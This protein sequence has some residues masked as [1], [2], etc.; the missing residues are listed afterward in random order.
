[1]L[2]TLLRRWITQLEGGPA[3]SLTIREIFRRFYGVNVGL[4]SAG[5]CAMRPQL[6]H[7]GTNIGRYASIF[8][9]VRTFT[10]NHTTSTKST[11]GFFDNPA[12]GKVTTDLI[13]WGKLVIG[14]GV[15]IGHNAIVLPPTETIG[16][17]AV[18]TAGSVVCANVPPYAIV[19]GFPARVVG[20]R[21]NKQ[22]I[23]ALVV[24]RWW[25]KSPEELAE[26]A[27]YFR[28]L[29]TDTVA[30]EP[31]SNRRDPDG[32]VSALARAVPGE[33]PVKR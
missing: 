4:Y 3:Y 23:D 10:R 16:D 31:S 20:F 8:E 19:S 1:M 17:G 9:T 13:P 15:W 2:R 7:R 12:G 28:R 6:F 32:A 11:H 27:E 14:N 22:I 24:S 33:A 26:N 25:E 18:I 30:Q 29:V 21:F 5:P